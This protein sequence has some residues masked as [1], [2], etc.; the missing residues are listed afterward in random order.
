MG[1]RKSGRGVPAGSDLD[2][3]IRNAKK[4]ARLSQDILDVTKIESQSLLLQKEKFNLNQVI[5]N[6]VADSRNQITKENKVN[7]VKLELVFKG[8]S[9]IYIE[10]DKSRIN[11]V[12][13]NL[14][15]NAIKFTKVVL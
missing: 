2:V 5:L 7:S 15:V 10:A 9:D 13:S 6:A 14:L 8:D 3:I 1:Y 4:L 11:Q 12:L